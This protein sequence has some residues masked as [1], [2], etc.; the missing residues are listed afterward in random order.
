MGGETCASASCQNE[1]NHRIFISVVVAHMKQTV[2]LFSPSILKETKHKR[3][4]ERTDSHRG[5]SL[6]L[7]IRG[8]IYCCSNWNNVSTST[9]K[10]HSM[11]SDDV[12][13]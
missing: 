6:L 1:K 3:V 9:G 2:I 8:F 13:W 10:D 5:V 4:I 7:R 11:A 12:I